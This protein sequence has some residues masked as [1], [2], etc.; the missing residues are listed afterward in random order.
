MTARD[1]FARVAVRLGLPVKPPMLAERFP[2]HR[3]GEGSYGWLTVRED[4]GGSR[5]TIGAWCSTARESAI[6]LG[7]NHRTDWATTYPFSVLEPRLQH[8]SGHPASNGDV[9]IGSDVWLGRGSTVM[10]GVTIG[11]GAVVAAHAVVT[12]DVPPYA[13]VGGVPAKVLRYRFDPPTIER[14][15]ALRWWDWPYERIVAAGPALLSDRIED[16]LDGAE[17][18]EI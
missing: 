10:S 6:I 9:R 1:L 16:F 13:I 4:G 7:G 5:L 14:L 8:I 11:D 12:R 15:L 18:G 3:I 2:R 17:S